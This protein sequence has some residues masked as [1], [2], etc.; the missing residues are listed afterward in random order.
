MIAQSACFE[1][2]SRKSKARCLQVLQQGNLPLN[3]I[4]HIRR[5]TCLLP[6]SLF[7]LISAKDTSRVINCGIYRK[8]PKHLAENSMVGEIS[9]FVERL[10][11]GSSSHIQSLVPVSRGVRVV[12]PG[13]SNGGRLAIKKA[14][15]KRSGYV[16][17]FSAPPRT[18]TYPKLD[19]F[20]LFVWIRARMA[21]HRHTPPFPARTFGQPPGF[22]VHG[23]PGRRGPWP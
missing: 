17:G 20:V 22:A 11:R 3:P 9:A 4:S 13:T 8:A 19:V 16:M 15:W 2:A 12:V 10:A 14:T 1:R 5:I 23:F 18:R 21:P 6:S 7:F